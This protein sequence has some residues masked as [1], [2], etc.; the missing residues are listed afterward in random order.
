MFIEEQTLPN[1]YL[2]VLYTDYPDGGGTIT[3]DEIVFQVADIGI[4]AYRGTGQVFGFLPWSIRGVGMGAE[5]RDASHGG[6][7]EYYQT[8]TLTNLCDEMPMQWTLTIQLLDLDTYTTTTRTD[9]VTV[10]TT[11]TYTLRVASGVTNQ[12]LYVIA[13]SFTSPVWP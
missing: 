13:E 3:G 8:L 11:T 5:K 12:S 10:T 6:P 9:T 1:V 4:G 7:Y 2:S